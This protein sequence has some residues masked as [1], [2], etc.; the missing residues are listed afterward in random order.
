MYKI[1]THENYLLVAI[2]E[3]F[4]YSAIK[5]ILHHETGLPEYAGMD[6]IW[7]IGP[8]HALV[9]LG[10]LETVVADFKSMCPGHATRQ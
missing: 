6:D 3:D 9:S 1:T 2:R 5:A 7:L 8:H 10:D 4:G